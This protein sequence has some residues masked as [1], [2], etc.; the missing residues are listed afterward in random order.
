MTS[1]CFARRSACLTACT[2][3]WPNLYFDRGIIFR[4]MFFRCRLVLLSCSKLVHRYRP[5]SST[6]SKTTTGNAQRSMCWM[7]TS[8]SSSSSLFLIP[9]RRNHLR[10]MLGLWNS[11]F[12]VHSLSSGNHEGNRPRQ[13]DR[14]RG[15]ASSASVHRS[16]HS[17]ISMAERR[18]GLTRGLHQRIDTYF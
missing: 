5:M 1:S 10:S 4:L 3:F 17:S 13:N 6:T 9:R 11:L 14:L 18:Q 12:A 7:D 2:S 8:D 15:E 16:I